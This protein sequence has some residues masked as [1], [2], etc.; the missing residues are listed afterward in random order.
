METELLIKCLIVATCIE[1]VASFQGGPGLLLGERVETGM[2]S[3]LI[4]VMCPFSTYQSLV[5]QVKLDGSMPWRAQ[6]LTTVV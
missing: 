5:T 6:R 4:L 2:Q 3:I 1:N